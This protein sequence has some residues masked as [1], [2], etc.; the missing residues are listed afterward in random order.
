MWQTTDHQRPSPL[1][2][3]H[4]LSAAAAAAAS[5]LLL[6]VDTS[7]RGF[8]FLRDGP[9]DMRMDPCAALSAEELI[10]TWPEEELGRMFWEFGEE[11]HWR[12][13]A[14]RVAAARERQPITTTQQ[15]VAAIGGVPLGS[16]G[17][18]GRRRGG[19]GSS[20]AKQKHPATR[21]FQAIRIAVNGELA[22]IAAAVP[23]AIDCLRPG[24]R[25][26]VITFHSLE[27]RIVKWAFRRAAGMA[28]SDGPLPSYC[29]PPA[30]AQARVDSAA[31]ASPRRKQQQPAQPPPQR[32]EEEEAPPARVRILTRRPVGPSEDEERANVRSR[33]AKLRVVEKLP[34]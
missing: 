1:R 8:S 34:S 32:A 13:V 4:R 15:L 5:C 7:E 28:P 30:A 20:K 23:D 14:R 29:L 17:D 33:S 24:G 19:S 22:S 25:L 6:Q 10:N 12:A 21:V 9:L 11:R 27:D 2:P 31:A 3:L 26:S 18:G 16:S